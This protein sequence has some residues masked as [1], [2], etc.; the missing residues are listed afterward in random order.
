MLIGGAAV[1]NIVWENLYP[2]FEANSFCRLRKATT[3]TPTHLVMP[4]P[5]LYIQPPILPP[6]SS[7]KESCIGYETQNQTSNNS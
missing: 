2:H 7:P 1:C 3:I 4:P 5:H 6:F